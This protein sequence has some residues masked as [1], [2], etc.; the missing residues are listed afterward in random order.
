MRN[1]KFG[2]FEADKSCV[3]SRLCSS[4]TIRVCKAEIP[5]QTKRIQHNA[6]QR[7][8][9]IAMFQHFTS[10]LC[11][12]PHNFSSKSAVMR[13][14]IKNIH[15]Q[16]N[17]LGDFMSI[18]SN[19]SLQLSSELSTNS[20]WSTSTLFAQC[21][22]IYLYAYWYKSCQYFQ[23]GLS[24]NIFNQDSLIESWS[25]CIVHLYRYPRYPRFIQ[26]WNRFHI[27]NFLKIDDR[28]SIL[29]VWYDEWKYPHWGRSICL[30]IVEL[31]IFYESIQ[32][33]NSGGFANF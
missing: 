23:S 31:W 24:I 8:T 19:S 3:S 25:V 17:D 21:Y 7:N 28:Y 22:V 10:A 6:G 33:W 13:T 5:R 27:W 29:W 14:E 9:I 1:G 30:A 12:Y 26:G 20:N 16:W 32:I 18:S 11:R 15:I 2:H 4:G